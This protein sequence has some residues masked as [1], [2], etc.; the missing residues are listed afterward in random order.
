MIIVA[1]SGSTKADWVAVTPKNT[2]MV[3]TMGFNPIY[4]SSDLIRD[5]VQTAF[6]D[7][8]IDVSAVTHVYY[9]GTAIWDKKKKQIIEKAVQQVFTEAEIEVEHDLLGAAR[10]TCGDSPGISCILGTGSN[11]CLYD[12]TEIID[13][14]TN[15]GYFIGDE[16]SGAHLG[17]ALVKAY[18]YRELPIEL[19]KALE[20]L[21]PGGKQEFLTN[22]Y[23]KPS[24]NVY[25]ASLTRFIGAHRDHFFIQRL[26]AESFSE[27]IDR[28]LRKY[29]NHLSLPVHFI[30]SIAYHFQDFLRILLE[31]RGM[32]V[33]IFIKKPVDTLVDYH[34][35]PD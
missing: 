34:R 23:N 12:G 25:L 31:E 27:F 32:Q 19:S 16:G 22:I 1:D 30:G 21:V 29:S 20:E 26:I 13:N 15:L 2:H 4:H 18:F 3:H 6:S 14:V 35:N 11:T 17:K 7:Q 9:Y 24:P 10:S 8:A 5:K 33:G 28:H